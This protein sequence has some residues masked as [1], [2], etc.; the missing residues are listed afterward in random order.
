[1]KNCKN[2]L[3]EAKNQHCSIPRGPG[4]HLRTEEVRAGGK[5]GRRVSSCLVGIEVL[6]KFEQT[7]S[8]KFVALGARDCITV[9]LSLEK[10]SACD[11]IIKKILYWISCENGT[12]SN[13]LLILP[14]FMLI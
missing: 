12:T 6:S 14:A 11:S 9:Q 1:M 3:E 4:G 10:L 2:T 7:T 13:M 8:F 5:E